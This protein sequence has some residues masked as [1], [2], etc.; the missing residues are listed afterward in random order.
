MP[1]ARDV[2]DRALSEADL[3]RWVIETAQALGWMVYHSRKTARTRKDDTVVWHTSYTGDRGFLDLV[4][5]RDGV[6]LIAELKSQKG[7]VSSDQK[8]W[9]K[10][11]GARAHVWR[12]SN[13]DLIEEILR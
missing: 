6:V 2:M 8:L 5:A 4:L 13:R 9:I 12:P 7:T 3:Q 11:L 1:S 10:A